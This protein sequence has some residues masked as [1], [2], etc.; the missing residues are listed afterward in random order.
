[1][2]SS[3]GTRPKYVFTF[4]GPMV[5]EVVAENQRDA[6]EMLQSPLEWARWNF[7]RNADLLSAVREDEIIEGGAVAETRAPSAGD[8]PAPSLEDVGDGA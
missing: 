1:M 3:D 7:T 4:M 8:L 2:A 5:I 6:Q